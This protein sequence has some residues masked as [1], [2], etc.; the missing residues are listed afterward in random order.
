MVQSLRDIMGTERVIHNI[1]WA[2]LLTPV[3]SLGTLAGS[4]TE[5]YS[6]TPRGVLLA[7]FWEE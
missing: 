1:L 6:E 2:F 3:D 4:N 5:P 7:C